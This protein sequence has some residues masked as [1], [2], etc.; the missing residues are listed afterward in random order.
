MGVILAIDDSM[1]VLAQ[2]QRFSMTVAPESSFVKAKSGEKGIELAK[3][4]TEEIDIAF[5]DY[6]MEGLNGIEVMGELVNIM[7][8]NKMVLLT[9]NIQEA[10]VDKVKEKGANFLAKPMTSEKYKEI[11]D[12]VMNRAQEK[13]A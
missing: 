13:S 3:Q 1:V 11:Y 8:I 10:V 9:A 12:I 5:I 2:L 7:P 4:Q 6:N